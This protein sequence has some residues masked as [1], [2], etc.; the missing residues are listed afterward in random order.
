MTFLKVVLVGVAELIYPP[1]LNINE[2]EGNI[3]SSIYES[4]G[5][6]LLYSVITIYVYAGS[7][8]LH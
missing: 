7:V 2:Y 1:L 4:V 8:K 6:L 5:I 3:K